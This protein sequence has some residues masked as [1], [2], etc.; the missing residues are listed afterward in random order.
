[1]TSSAR[2]LGII[3]WLTW[4]ALGAL[5]VLVAIVVSSAF[6]TIEALAEFF[7]ALAPTR[8]QLA[9]VVI[10]IGTCGAVVLATTGVLVGYVSADRFFRPSALR[11][12]NVLIGA[13][14]AGTVLVV[15]GLFFIPGPPQLF[16][17]V[18]ACVPTGI[19]ITLV[20]L[21][22][23]ALLRRAGAMHLELDEVV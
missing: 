9:I 13:V 17:L 4:I 10:G 22:M 7:P 11:W 15:V 21:V 14:A 8:H 20:L 2:R 16:L 1:M 23:R 5:M 18:E 6:A 3:A 19:T 12:V